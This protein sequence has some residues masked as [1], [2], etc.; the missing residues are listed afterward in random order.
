MFSLMVFNGRPMLSYI[1]LYP[2]FKDK[3]VHRILTAYIGKAKNSSML[4]G[5][6]KP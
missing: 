2:E 3:E 1:S 4:K 6:A 5:Y